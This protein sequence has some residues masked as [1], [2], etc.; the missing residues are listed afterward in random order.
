MNKVCDM[1]CYIRSCWED[2]HANTNLFLNSSVACHLLLPLNDCIHV[3][4]LGIS[5][6]SVIILPKERWQKEHQT[7]N[8]LKCIQ[9][10]ISRNDLRKRWE[11]DADSFVNRF[12]TMDKSWG[13]RFMSETKQESEEWKHSDSPTPKKA[14][15]IKLAG[16]AMVSVWNTGGLFSKG[17]YSNWTILCD[18]VLAA[19]GQYR[20]HVKIIVSLVRK[21]RFAYVSHAHAC[22]HTHRMENAY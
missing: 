21:C 6:T 13:R 4:V 5:H 7:S 3:K 11:R 22:T 2:A 19:S 14:T 20:L 10:G 9:F 18:L 15:V 17:S 12:I 16:K 8:T 1:L